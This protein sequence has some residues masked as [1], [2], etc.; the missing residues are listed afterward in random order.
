[1]SNEII[2]GDKAQRIFGG[3]GYWAMGDILINGPEGEIQVIEKD[4]A[5][6]YIT[7]NKIGIFINASPYTAG[8]NYFIFFQKDGENVGAIG[9]WKYTSAGVSVSDIILRSQEGESDD[10]D[11]YVTM[12]VYGSGASERYNFYQIS[13]ALRA[14]VLTGYVYNFGV[15]GQHITPRIDLDGDGCGSLRIPQRASDPSVENARIYY[16]TTTNKVRICEGSS[17]KDVV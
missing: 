2:R 14:G 9:L 4:Y 5:H 6:T 7:L 13:K 17:W 11:T 8:K 10:S 12:A 3:K 1:M 15:D 16:N